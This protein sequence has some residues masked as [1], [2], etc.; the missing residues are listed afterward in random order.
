MTILTVGTGQEY[1][2][3]TAAVNA[4]ASGDTVDVQAGTY[5][6][7]FVT[8]AKSLTLQAVG[9]EVV[10]TETTQPPNGKAMIDEGGAGLTV[11]I[12]GFDISGVTVP[13]A[14][15]AA[16]RYEGGALSLTN[17]FFHNNQNGILGAPDP[18]GTI[19]IESSEFAANGGGTGNTHNIYV[20]VIA[21]L[22]VNNSYIHNANVGHEI[23]SRAA[24]NTITNN[25]IFDNASTASYSIDLPNG[26]NATITGNTI[27]QGPNTQNP[28][29]MA[30]AE[31]GQSNPGT[32]V[33]IS[34]NTI[35]ND[36]QASNS[37][38]LLSSAQ[39][40]S[41]TNNSVWGLTD[42]QLLAGGNLAE[43]GTVFLATRPTLDTSSLSFINPTSGTPPPPPVVLPPP[44]VV[45]PPPVAVPPPPVVVPPP[46]VA[47]PPPPVAVPP[48]PVVA[49]PPVVLPPPPVTLPPP[50]VAPPPTTLPPPPVTLP[51]PPVAPPPTTLPPPP[52]TLPPPPVVVP[53][54][55]VV[56]PPPPP[57]PPTSHGH[58]GHDHTPP[59]AVAIRDLMQDLRMTA[60]DM[61]PA[62]HVNWAAPM[63]VISEHHAGSASWNGAHDTPKAFASHGNQWSGVGHETQ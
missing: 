22:T 38:F 44:P 1:T 26:G 20:G 36:D 4:A 10:M 3:I 25:R 40:L 61:I 41:F 53:P 56:V 32:N 58:N 18:N 27:E 19:D 39:P 5:T 59:P 45:V 9:G 42:A 16:I 30:Y 28:A 63:A 46:P 48:P 54:P 34:G 24:S 55:P 43:S 62:A 60:K 8:V 2:T 47:L 31:E 51:P 6:D 7:D 33:S 21:S 50:P 17:D 13:D 35:V 14:N 11:A 29:I 49:P 57:P 52:V 15:G 23:K 12:N 37:H